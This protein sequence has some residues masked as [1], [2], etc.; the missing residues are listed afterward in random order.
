MVPDRVGWEPLG[1][2]FAKDFCVA[3]IASGDFRVVGGFFWGVQCDST[4][5]VTVIS[6]WLRS[7]DTSGKEFCS[8]GIQ[9]S[10]YNGEMG[11]IDPTLFPIYLWLHCCKPWITKNRLVFTKVG[12]E[13]L[14]R[15]GSGPGSDV[16]DGVV[17]EVSASVLCSINIEQFAGLRELFDREFK[18]FSIREVHEIFSRS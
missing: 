9:A 8:L 4:Y 16:Q 5:E 6:N 2:L 15:D 3:S 14:E 10:E 17:V 13:E 11:V 12:E 1:L 18:P 7:I